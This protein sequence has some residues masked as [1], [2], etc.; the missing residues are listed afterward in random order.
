[1]ARIGIA[2]AKQTTGSRGSAEET[3]GTARDICHIQECWTDE[4]IH[5]GW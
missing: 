1:M 4:E 3:T 2:G 5:G